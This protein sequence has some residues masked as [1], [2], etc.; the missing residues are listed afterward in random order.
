MTSGRVNIKAILDDPKKRKCLMVSCIIAIQ[1]RE[2]I[3][4]SQQQAETAYDTVQREN[5][6]LDMT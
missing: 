5:P 1:A 4:T 2:G 3:E 6:T